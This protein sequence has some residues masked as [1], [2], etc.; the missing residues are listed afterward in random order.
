MVSALGDPHHIEESKR[1]G[2]NDHI[3]KP[4]DPHHLIQVV[5]DLTS[6]ASKDR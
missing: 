2:A 6:A 5:S 3:Q 1:R 4:F